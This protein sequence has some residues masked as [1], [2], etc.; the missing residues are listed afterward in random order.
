MLKE[1]KLK[2]FVLVEELNID[3]SDNLS[4]LTGETG[5]GKSVIAG[6][7]HIVLG[8]SL[9]GDVFYDKSK[10]VEIEA[11][12]IVDDFMKDSNFISLLEEYGIEIELTP[13]SQFPTPNSQFP[14]PNSQFPT[15]HS[16]FPTPNSQFPTPNSQF[17]T[18]NSLR[19]RNESLIFFYR[20]IKPD[21]RSTIFINGRKHTNATVKIFRNILLDF[22]SQREQQ[23]LF[24]EDTQLLYLDKYADLLQDREAFLEV[25]TQWQEAIK[26]LKKYQDEIKKNEEKILLYNYQIDELIAAKLTINEETDLDSE[27]NLLTNAKEILDNYSE[28]QIELFESDRTVFDILAYYKSRLSNYTKDSKLIADTVENLN[29]SITALEDISASSRYIDEEISIDEKRLEEVENRIKTIYDLKTK[30]RKDVHKMIE[31]IAEMQAFVAGFS[32][33]AIEEENLKNE[34]SHLQKRA[35]EI[36]TLLN[37]KRHEAAISMEKNIID[38]LV[39]LAIPDAD[40]KIC[41]EYL[42]DLESET[43]PEMD[44]FTTTGLN[45]VKYTFSANKGSILQELKATISGGELSRLLLVIKS[46][47]AKKLPERTIIFDEIDTGIGGKTAMALSGFISEISQNHQILCITHLP[48]I[49]ALANKHLK[50]EKISTLEKNLITVT[51]LSYNDRK[52]EI[53]R[54]LAGNIT[55]ASLEHAEELLKQ[56]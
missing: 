22:H 50:I 45:Q 55:N 3:F 46:I 56:K 44:I 9:K 7:I 4:V 14:T 13:S 19:D 40:F 1:L 35:F 33:N 18:P 30:Y 48:Q 51:D 26:K 24:D 47:L 49:A 43:L 54:M 6:A 25:Y 27:Y 37:K 11:T 52:N 39:K 41:L 29:I 34:I 17:P 28:M 10:N 16:Q 2:N 8:E 36:A 32:R 21:G 5:A 31:Y 42:Y 15:P 12:F 38:N 53:A 20:E 23:S